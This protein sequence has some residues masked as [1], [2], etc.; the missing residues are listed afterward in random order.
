MNEASSI[1]Q[2]VQAIKHHFVCLVIVVDDASTDHTA[3]VARRAGAFVLSHVT[4]LGAWRA[5]QTGI[6]YALAQG[7]NQVLTCDADGQHPI[8]A[9]KELYQQ[10]SPNADCVIGAC[11]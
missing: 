1:G 10:A 2:V 9:L 7:M 8:E 3:L 4:N 11:T 6:R 5:T